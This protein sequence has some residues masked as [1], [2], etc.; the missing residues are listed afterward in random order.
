[1][2]DRSPGR[3]GRLP[4]GNL[5]GLGIREKSFGDG[6]GVGLLVDLDVM[7]PEVRAAGD[8]DELGVA[9]PGGYLLISRVIHLLK[10]KSI[11]LR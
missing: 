3:G 11:P 2:K 1:M 8:S 5:D 10:S 9:V 6:A 4:W 7:F